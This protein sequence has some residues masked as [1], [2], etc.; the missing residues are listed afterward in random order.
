MRKVSVCWAVA[1][2]SAFATPAYAGTIFENDVRWIPESG[3]FVFAGNCLFSTICGQ[4]V[5]HP[6]VF[7]AQLFSVTDHTTLLSARVDTG[8]VAPNP[9][10]PLSFS[11]AVYEVDG[12]TGLPDPCYCRGSA[13]S[14]P[15]PHTKSVTWAPRRT[16]RLPSPSSR[17]LHY[18]WRQGSTTSRS[19]PKLLGLICV[20]S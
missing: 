17:H 19:M 9:P 5:G 15:E 18:T 7:A 13:K 12:S 3:Y 8:G 6:D 11:Y 20:L 10:Y 4:S 14:K 16:S 1:L 2:L